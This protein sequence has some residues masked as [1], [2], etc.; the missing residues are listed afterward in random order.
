MLFVWL[1]DPYN[2]GSL[3]LPVR[4]DARHML[5]VMIA[6]PLFLGIALWGFGKLFRSANN[7]SID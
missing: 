7:R 5:A 1:T 4:E 6:P 3:S 2:D